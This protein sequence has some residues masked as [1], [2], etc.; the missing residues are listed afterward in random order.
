M[1]EGQKR[2]FARVLRANMTDAE[3]ELWK[4]VRRKQL[5]GYK[6]RRQHP[7]GPYI[8]D[9]VCLPQSLV[10]EIDGGQHADS[11]YDRFRKQGLARRGFRILRFWNNE[12]LGNIEGVCEMILR[13]LGDSG[14]HPG[15]PPHAGEGDKP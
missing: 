9:F 3:T 12:V 5:L 6:F 8:V 11:E 2:D 7:I 15:L 1:R 4:H 10:I 14:P 13:H